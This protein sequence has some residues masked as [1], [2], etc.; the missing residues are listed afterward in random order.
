MLTME[1][2]E[3]TPTLKVKRANVNS[4]WADTIDSIYE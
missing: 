2:D 1:D 3:L 4:G